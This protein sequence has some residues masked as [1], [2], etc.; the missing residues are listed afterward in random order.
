MTPAKIIILRHGE[1]KN[2]HEL[3]STGALRAQALAA[4]FLGKDGTQALLSGPPAA[5]LA[6][7]PHTVETATPAA[8]TWGLQPQTSPLLGHHSGADEDKAL[9]EATK[10]AAEDV[11]T[12]SAYAGKTV[13]MV[14]EH[15]RIASKEH[16]AAKT[17]LRALLN[18]DQAPKKWEDDNYNYFWIVTSG[19]GNQVTVETKQQAFTDRFANLPNN[20]WGAPEQNK[21]ADCE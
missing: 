17:S 2:G 12:N 20:A 5:V 8:H 19:P 10:A 16:N 14:W 13:I 21:G 9:D 15:K 4:Q 6:I 1:K 3:C 7:T 11:L 18:L